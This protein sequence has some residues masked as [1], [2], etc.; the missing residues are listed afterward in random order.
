[1]L[2]I[3]WSP[4]LQFTFHLFPLAPTKPHLISPP[5]C[6]TTLSSLHLA[7][8]S[9]R[10]LVTLSPCH[11]STSPPLHL[12]TP[13]PFHSHHHYV[14]TSH[15]PITLSSS[16]SPHPR[17]LLILDLASSSSLPRL[18]SHLVLVL[19]SSSSS[20]CSRPHLVFV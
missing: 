17:P 6:L 3:C 15:R 8:S 13:P 11:L 9:P 14:M 2:I 18:H 12:V 19:A 7:T 5:R 20:P 16:T 10:R 4:L 1:M